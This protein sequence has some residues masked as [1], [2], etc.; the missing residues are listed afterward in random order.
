[1]EN[2]LLL[3]GEFLGVDDSRNIS[4]GVP[5][6]WQSESS[7]SVL[8]VSASSH[9][10]SVVLSDF[11]AYSIGTNT[12]G[13]LGIGCSSPVTEL[14]RVRSDF[15]FTATACTT[16]CTFWQA[17]DDRVFV[18]GRDF[19]DQP[20]PL[21][22]FRSRQIRAFD[23]TLAVLTTDGNVL[24]W[25][26]FLKDVDHP[27]LTRAPS[28]PN[29]ISCGGHFAVIR[30]GGSV[31]RFA[32]DASFV[33]LVN[34]SRYSD[35]VPA[36]IRIAS[37]AN[38][39]LVLDDQAN[40]WLHG[41][42]GQLTRKINYT[43]IAQNMRNVFAMP[44]HC[45]FVGVFGGTFTFGENAS[46]QLA[47]GTTCKRTRVV[48]AAV[49]GPTVAVVGGETFSLFLGSKFDSSLFTIRMDEFVPGQMT[50]PFE[51]LEDLIDANTTP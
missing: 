24:L 4:H 7:T 6:H 30:C 31:F 17:S 22:D 38:Y 27:L 5:L 32:E 34:T 43:P 15:A 12:H 33:P 50:C 3:F 41:Q 18:A 37:A 40:V 35:G 9:T 48:D 2:T 39:T 14:T 8:D 47:D 16:D 1:M 11:S 28:F 25:P 10:I 44:N 21:R 45:A 49:V 20:Q 26:N 51:K 13:Q 42:I 19:T 46:G 36:A 29:E 23:A